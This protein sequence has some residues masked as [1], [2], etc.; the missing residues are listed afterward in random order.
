[1]TESDD[2]ESEKVVVDRKRG[3]ADSKYSLKKQE[4]D[5]KKKKGRV[6]VEV[7]HDETDRRQKAII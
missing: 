3:R 4:K 6:L 2:D 5:A 1:M 7:E